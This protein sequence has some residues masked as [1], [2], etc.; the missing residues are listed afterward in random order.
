MK[1]GS[2]LSFVIALCVL[3]PSTLLANDYGGWLS[4]DPVSECFIIDNIDDHEPVLIYPG[5]TTW[6]RDVIGPSMR[7][8]NGECYVLNSFIDVGGGTTTDAWH[9]LGESLSGTRNLQFTYFMLGFQYGHSMVPSFWDKVHA[10]VDKDIATCDIRKSVEYHI[11]LTPTTDPEYAPYMAY[12]IVVEKWHLKDGRVIDAPKINFPEW[13]EIPPEALEPGEE[14]HEAYGRITGALVAKATGCEKVYEEYHN[15]KAAAL[16]ETYGLDTYFQDA[17]DLADT[18]TTSAYNNTWEQTDVA[19]GADAEE[20]VQS[21]LPVIPFR[22]PTENVTQ[23]DSSGPV[24]I[25]FEWWLPLA[26]IAVVVGAFVLRKRF[27]F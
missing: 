22:T 12:E 20:A 2:A 26:G 6:D 24:R 15:G 16:I 10:I 11:E 14:L 13:D 1:H 21:P 9:F 25:P 4:D 19:S 17:D 7:A 18:T 8:Q 27:P 3:F 5:N 23:E